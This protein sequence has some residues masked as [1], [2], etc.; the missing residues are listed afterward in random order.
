MAVEYSDDETTREQGGRIGESTIAF[1]KQ[2]LE[3]SFIDAAL[4]LAAGEVSR[5]VKTRYGYH[6]IKVDSLK[7]AEGEEW[8]KERENIHKELLLNELNASGELNKWITAEREKAEIEILDPALRGYRFKQEEK[9]EEAALAYAKALKDKR[10]RRTWR[11]TCQRL[12][13]TGRP[14]IMRRPWR[15]WRRSR[16]GSGENRI[17]PWPRSGS[18]MPGER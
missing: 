4:Q 15:S 12:R 17:M 8:E 6:I 3:Q 7:L 5:P 13:L 18:C 16:K 2:T 9:W 1:Y 11:Y 14:G 10:Y